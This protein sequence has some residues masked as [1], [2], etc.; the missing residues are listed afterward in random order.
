MPMSG[1][2]RAMGAERC[3]RVGRCRGPGTHAAASVPRTYNVDMRGITVALV[4]L[5][6][7]GAAPLEA[8][9]PIQKVRVSKTVVKVD[10]I[11]SSTR[12]LVYVTP[13]GIRNSMTVAP[14]V[15]LFDEL[16]EGDVVVVH[17]IEALVAKVKPGAPLTLVT[18]TTA[19]AKAN[20]VDPGVRVDQQLTQVVT[21]DAIDRAM[22]TVTYHGVDSRRVMRQVQDVTALA[23]LKAG[24]VVELTFTRERAVSIE[25]APQQ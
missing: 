2:R 9:E 10:R 17:Y 3:G 6:V 13:D 15:T 20:V 12:G 1:K 7:A 24:D 23:S 8:Q 25:R 16:R 19:E 11:D 14:E 18:D 5:L 21:I 4:A 22:R